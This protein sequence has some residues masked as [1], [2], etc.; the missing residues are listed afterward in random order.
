ME[1]IK[2]VNGKHK[3]FYDGKY[4][5]VPE[6]SVLVQ[7][8]EVTLRNRIKRGATMEKLLKPTGRISSMKK[9]VPMEEKEK[10]ICELYNLFNELF[11]RGETHAG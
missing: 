9:T 7:I 1:H 11:N 8:P 2:W 3:V 4:R 10:K 5:G 6:L